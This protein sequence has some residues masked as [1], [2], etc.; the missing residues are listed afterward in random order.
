MNNYSKIINTVDS[1]H[2]SNKPS[3]YAKVW[4]KI[5]LSLT[6]RDNQKRK[7]P[8]S[9]VFLEFKN[10]KTRREVNCYSF[11]NFSSLYM[12]IYFW[13]NE[14]FRRSKYNRLSP[15]RWDTMKFS[16]IQS[17]P[18]WIK[19]WHPQRK[20]NLT[21]MFPCESKLNLE[22]RVKIIMLFLCQTVSRIQWGFT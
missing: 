13:W 11:F 17:L 21:D 10:Y 2:S 4:F 7:F 22:T 6:N 18:L 19:W 1:C 8:S 15:L 12:G 20:S 9:S 16:K 3:K 5:V 14:F